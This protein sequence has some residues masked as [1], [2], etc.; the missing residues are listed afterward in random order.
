MGRP[1]NVVH[2]L[3]TRVNALLTSSDRWRLQW[4]VPM[5]FGEDVHHGS[6]RLPS[7]SLASELE[8]RS[9]LGNWSVG[10][11]VA[12]QDISHEIACK[13]LTA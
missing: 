1:P 4:L 10:R 7:V 13:V 12:L 5:A 9:E 3:S 8:R 6:V 2:C 11:E